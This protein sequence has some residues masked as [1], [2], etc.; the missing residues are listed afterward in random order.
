MEIVSTRAVLGHHLLVTQ[1]PAGSD[2]ERAGPSSGG[3]LRADYGDGGRIALVAPD[4][5]VRVLT[6]GFHSACE[7]DVSFDGKRFLFA[8]RR[9]ATERWNIFEMLIDGSGVRQITKGPG[10]CRSPGYQSTQYV[11]TASEPWYQITFVGTVPGSLNEIGTA[12]ATALYACKLDGTE[13][14]RLTYNLSS[15]YDP[16]IMWDGRL[17]YASWQRAR[18]SHGLLG[19]IRIFGVNTDG[20][21][22]A[23]Y[24]QPSARRIQH[25]P[26]TTPTG[27]AVFVEC[28]RAPWDGAG[29]LACVETR[30][31]LR[32]YRA[33][34]I[35]ADGL[36]HSPSPLPDGRILVSRR[37]ADGAGTHGVYRLDLRSGRLEPVFDDPGAHDV[38]AKAVV[39]R[40]EPDGRSSVVSEGDPHG[41][42]Y[43]LNIYQS[44]LKDKTWMP[45]GSV[46]R[47]RVLE[48]LPRR[49]GGTAAQA[50]S[51]Q[52]AGIEHGT[53]QLALRRILGEAP[54]EPD[55]S[56]NLEVPSNTPIEL[57]ILDEHGMALR[58]C[59]WIWARSHQ[60]QGCIGCHEDPELSPDNY[61]TQSLAKDSYPIS[62]PVEQRRAVDFRRD[63]MPLIAKKCAGCHDKGG[64]APY[65]DA[66][67]EL[68]IGPI[69]ITSARRTYEA[70]LAPDEGG[71]QR[72]GRGKYVDPGQARTSPLV[73]HLF[74]RNTSRPWDGPACQR[75]AKPIEPG[76]LE[77]LSDEERRRFVEWIDLGAP[78]DSIPK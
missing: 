50:T 36:F 37:G 32:T 48:G 77:P 19:Q 16:A 78:W 25:M 52:A 68:A 64:A 61:V 30:R 42:L 41:K 24:V 34:T 49:D 2:A 46:K 10:D 43:C 39:A 74:G 63:L 58:S 26:C 47:L 55:G 38:Q 23:A 62:P 1:I 6:Q 13:V 9:T 33:L 65:L 45:A 66:G 70:L 29:T 18:L 56:F 8:G 27:Q 28:D 67:K 59:G 20:G 51:A 53:P 31:P 4:G 69:S 21:D 60:S 14:K 44:D 11:I 71:W 7:P 57:Q 12:P 75:Q 17:L 76:K 35:E 3:M 54:I 72:S 5:S 40:D 73:W 22:Y 15:D